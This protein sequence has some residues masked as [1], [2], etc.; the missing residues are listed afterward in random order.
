[1][2]VETIKLKELIP[3]RLNI[4]PIGAFKIEAAQGAA[5]EGHRDA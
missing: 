1:M 2:A 5:S 4:D 3:V